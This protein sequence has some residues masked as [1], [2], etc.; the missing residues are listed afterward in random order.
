MV[1]VGFLAPLGLALLARPIDA[2]AG[3]YGKQLLAL[4]LLS[5]ERPVLEWTRRKYRVRDQR[6]LEV[7][8]DPEWYGLGYSLLGVSF[9]PDPDAWG[10]MTVDTQDIEAKMLADGGQ[11]TTTNIPPGYQ[12]VPDAP[13]LRRGDR[14]GF[15]PN[16]FN[17]DSYYV[18]SGIS[19]GK[20]AGSAT[21]E[22]VLKRLLWAKDKYGGGSGLD[23]R[24]MMIAVGVLGMVS[25]L[26]GIGVFFL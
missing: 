1:V 3:A 19:R 15:V 2:L 13:E 24:Q 11:D 7:D 12:P 21:G 23:Q 5:F 22:R 4:Y 8:D 9:T 20:Y 6:E 25:F 18:H 16:R 26:S 10:T 17:D 14:G